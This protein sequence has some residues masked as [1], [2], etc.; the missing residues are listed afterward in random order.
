M[1]EIRTSGSEGEEAYTGR[2]S[3]PLSRLL[4]ITIV[5]NLLGGKHSKSLRNYLY[6][7]IRILGKSMKALMRI[8]NDMGRILRIPPARKILSL[9]QESSH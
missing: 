1:R 4:K 9:S 5:K 3:L 8:K 2:S 6:L 7:A